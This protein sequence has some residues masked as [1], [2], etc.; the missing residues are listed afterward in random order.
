MLLPDTSFML[1]VIVHSVLLSMIRAYYYRCS[2]VVEGGFGLINKFYTSKYLVLI[3]FWIIGWYS[4][5][6]LGRVVVHGTFIRP[7]E[8]TI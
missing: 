1:N 3:F 6:Q 2:G 5:L 7:S 8:L 4:T